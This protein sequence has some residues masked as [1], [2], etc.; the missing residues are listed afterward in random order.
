M[1]SEKRKARQR[2]LNT[3]EQADRDNYEGARR[4]ECNKML[5]NSKRNWV[6]DEIKEIEKENRNKNT[7]LFY[8]KINEQNKTYRGRISGMLNKDGMVTEDAEEYKKVWTEYFKEL[9]NDN[10]PNEEV[11]TEEDEE[12]ETVTEPTIEEVKEVINKSRKGKAPGKDG[13]NM[14]LI[15]YGGKE[16]QKQV[17]ALIQKIWREEKMPEEW[18]TGQIVTIQKRRPKEMR[19]L[20]RNYIAKYSF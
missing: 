20:Q 17:H 11:E 19:K 15:K 10:S 16:L 1:L 8:K 7:K 3:S 12:D 4:K 13:I 18:K 2:W 5:K 6:E 14:D 9:L